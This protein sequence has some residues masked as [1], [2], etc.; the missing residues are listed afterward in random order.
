MTNPAL[1]AAIAADPDDDTRRLAYADWLDEQDEHDRAELIRVQCEL[2]KP[3]PMT[4]PHSDGPICRC[5]R[6]VIRSRE[7]ELIDAHPEWTQWPC[8]KRVVCPDCINWKGR[9]PRDCRCIGSRRLNC[10][11]CGGEGDLL[12]DRRITW[13]RGWPGWVYVERVSE[14]VVEQMVLAEPT[15]QERRDGMVSMW[16]AKT[17]PTQLLTALAETPPWGVPLRGVIVEELRPHGLIANKSFTETRWVFVPSAI[18]PLEVYSLLIGE[19]L[20]PRLLGTSPPQWRTRQ[21]AVRAAA[22]A[23]PEFAR[24]FLAKAS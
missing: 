24:R 12:K 16:N 14:L 13:D 8:L 1:L 10:L 4:E 17:V 23:F 19:C 15:E 21:A 20:T 7:R 2:L 9:V 6:C 18:F 3:W 22:A 11:A 5:E